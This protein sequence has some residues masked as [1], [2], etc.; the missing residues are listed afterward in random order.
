MKSRVNRLI[1]A[2]ALLALTASWPLRAESGRLLPNDPTRSS[3]PKAIP[4]GQ[5]VVTNG[6]APETYGGSSNTW[7]TA[8]AWDAQPIDSSFTYSYQIMTGGGEGIAQSNASGS[9]WVHIPIHLPNGAR[10]TKIET[11][12]CDT[13]A[14]TLYGNIFVQDKLGPDHVTL[15]LTSSGTP[16]CIVETATLVSPITIDNNAETYFI[17]L[18]MGAVTDGSIIFGSMR[19]GYVLQ[20]SPAPSV[21]T[22]SD[23]PTG[24][25]YFKFVE[26]LAASG[27]TAGCGCG[28]F[29]PDTPLTRGQMAVY[30][31]VALGLHWP[32]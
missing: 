24:H 27:I 10:W 23:V 8:N 13:G 20:V 5:V 19:F 32:N 7:Y 25:P 30:H 2:M 22:F 18:N 14:A 1:I 28:K 26:A 11:E 9:P 12:Y 21:A 4:D 31:S 17:E 6:P 29:C 3:N 15:F 16:G